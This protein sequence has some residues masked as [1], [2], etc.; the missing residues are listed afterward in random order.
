MG[1]KVLGRNKRKE[2]EGRVKVG[3][4]EKGFLQGERGIGRIGRRRREEGGGWREEIEARDV[5]VQQQEIYESI[6]K[7]RWNVWYK[8]IMV[9]GVPKYLRERGKEGRMVRISRFRLENEMRGRRY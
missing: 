7:S 6:Q 4:T 8:E 3:E 9:M 2:G 5:E 1:E